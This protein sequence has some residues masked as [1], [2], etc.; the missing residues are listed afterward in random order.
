MELNNL[1]RRSM[2]GILSSA[3][4]G[5]IAAR[6]TKAAES[7][8]TSVPGQ[9]KLTGITNAGDRQVIT[10]VYTNVPPAPR[11]VAKYDADGRLL[12][13]TEYDR[14]GRVTST[15]DCSA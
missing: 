3:F 7:A 9:G 2:L 12:S 11:S 1:S 13:Y 8:P 4:L 14:Q 6:Q 5:W 15:K 10:Y